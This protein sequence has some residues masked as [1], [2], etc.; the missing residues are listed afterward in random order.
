MHASCN[1]LSLFGNNWYAGSGFVTEVGGERVIC[2]CAHNIVNATRDDRASRVIV[3]LHPTT[4]GGLQAECD[5]SRTFVA[6]AA[7]VALVR[8]Q[9]SQ[10]LQNVDVLSI[11]PFSSSPAVGDRCYMLGNP[12]DLDTGSLCDGVIRDINFAAGNLVESIVTSMPALAGNSGS[13][14][15]AANGEVIGILSYGLGS[16]TAN[17][18]AC[19]NWGASWRVIRVVMEYMQSASQ[20]F[21]GGHIGAPMYPVAAGPWRSAG[22]RLVGYEVAYSVQGIGTDEVIVAVEDQLIGAYPDYASPVAIYL[23]LRGTIQITIDGP[24]GRRNMSVTVLPLALLDDV[25]LGRNTASAKNTWHVL[26]PAPLH[27][28][29]SPESA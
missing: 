21:I 6:A 25:P 11:W 19:V 12:L 10:F 7:D 4:G 9:D 28:E 24:Y 2:T 23:K 8:L 3:A 15:M 26:G 20:H 13:A 17:T 16:S 14:I 1:V 22:T 18:L 29:K 27:K 5:L